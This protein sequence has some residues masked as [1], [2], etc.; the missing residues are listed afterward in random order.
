MLLSIIKPLSQSRIMESLMYF[1]AVSQKNIIATTT[2]IPEQSF[3]QGHGAEHR[4]LELKS[5][6]RHMSKT[7]DREEHCC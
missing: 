3:D 5:D 6:I 2:K 1:S 4:S 7:W